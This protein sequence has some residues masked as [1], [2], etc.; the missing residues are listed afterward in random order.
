MATSEVQKMC[1]KCSAELSISA[2]HKDASKS[3]G[4]HPWCKSCRLTSSRQRRGVTPERYFAK[5]RRPDFTPL[6]GK[7][8]ARWYQAHAQEERQKARDKRE[9]NPEPFRNAN[10][11]WRSKNIEAERARVRKYQQAN[12]HAMAANAAQRRALKLRATPS[13]ANKFF[14]SETYRL[15]DLRTNSL[16][17]KWVVDHIVPLRSNLVCGLHVEQNLRVIPETVNAMKGN[18]YWPNMPNGGDHRYE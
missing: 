5:D 7:A 14:I 1:S 16:G 8:S 4:F 17:V 13:W 12:A 3:D 9:C 11:R 18:R 2:F 10:R 15:A 6:D